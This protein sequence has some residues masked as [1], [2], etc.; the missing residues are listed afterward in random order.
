MNIAIVVNNFPSNSETF[1]I[2]KVI[3]LAKAK[4]SVTVF[5]LNGTGNKDLYELYH[6]KNL[7]NISI[8]Y[9]NL[10]K[11]IFEL[12]KFF[13]SNPLLTIS[14]FSATPKIFFSNIKSTLLTKHFN[15]KFD[16]V[17]F[18]YSGLGASLL[19]IIP[20]V[21]SKKVVSCRGSAEKVKPLTDATRKEKLQQLFNLV[22]GI[23]CVSEDM[24]QTITPYCSNIEKVFVNRPAIDATFFQPPAVKPQNNITQI[25]TVGRFTFQKGYLLLLMVAKKLAT[26]NI[27]FVWNIIG[28]GPQH[29]E[30]VFHIHTLGLEKCVKLV[31]KKNKNEVNQ[32]LASANMFVL[33]SVYEGIPNVVLEAMAMELPVIS[34]NCGGVEEVIETGIDGFIAP[35]YD[36]ETIAN[37]IEYLIAKPDKA[38]EMGRLARK[39]ILESFTLERQVNIFV[40]AYNKIIG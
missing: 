5:S 4:N 9:I 2:N 28:E 31:G 26:K 32:Y 39:K 18:E 38:N 13:L 27:N 30:L 12:I 36:V 19:E 6:F 10:P 23:H 16:I 25:L 8:K 40:E 34:T 37:Q 20:L 15:N 22:D 1:I 11:N 33:T 17:H 35:L 7:P 3:E 24:K 21:K 29:E 14:S